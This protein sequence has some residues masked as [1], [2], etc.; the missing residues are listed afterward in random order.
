MKHLVLILFLVTSSIVQSQNFLHRDGQN[1]VD[2][3]GN[4]VLLRGLGLGGWM[5]QEGYM[6]QTGDFAGPQHVI[7]QNI[8]NLIGKEK[9]KLFY[10]SYLANGITKRDID[11]LAAW[12]FNSVR[13]PMHYNLYTPPIEDEIN[14]EITWLDKGFQ[15]TDELL[16]WCK[17]NKMYLV[18]DLHAAPGGQGNDANISDYDKSKPSLWESEANQKKMIALWRKLADRYKNEPWIGGYDIINEPNWNFTG[19]N[20]NGCDETSNAPLRELMIAI[21]KAIREVDTNHI[22]FIEGN[23]WGNNYEGIL[24]VWD[25][26]IVLSFHKYW[27]YNTI[28]SIQKM[29]DYR[30]QYNIPIWLGESGE[31]SNVWF[32]EAISLVESNNIGWAFWPMKKIENIAGVTSVTKN[33]EFEIIRNYWKNGGEKPTEAFAFNALMQLA[34]NYKMEHVTIKRDVIDAMFRQ[35]KTNTTKPYKKHVVPGLVYATEYDLGTN[36]YAYLDND[37]VNYR[38]D[39]GKAVKWNSG[40]KM[41]NDGVDIQICNDKISNGYEVFD[42]RD[43]E[44]LQYTV[45]AN[46]KG[47]YNVLIRYANNSKKAKVHLENEKTHISKK[48]KLPVATNNEAPYRTFTIPDVTLEKGENQIK[49][50]FD[51]GGFILNSLEFKSNN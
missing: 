24:P 8:E 1:I 42:I 28:K 36:G 20:K 46:K 19:K 16:E 12:G 25:D 45:T 49:V 31:N 38:V 40:N 27:N 41:R 48:F 47:S 14:D 43:G 13:L 39:T 50:V 7:K 29:L 33:P 26:N 30:S 34:E 35:V 9:T 32:K 11:S 51:K 18:L 23:C 44:W 17:A 22:I 6:L 3:N 10:D 5:V 2:K 37:F 21:T 4:N 15:M